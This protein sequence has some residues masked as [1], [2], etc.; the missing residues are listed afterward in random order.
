MIDDGWPADLA[1]SQALVAYRDNL[2]LFDSLMQ[3][4][5]LLAPF[6]RGAVVVSASGNESRADEDPKHRIAVSLPAAADGVISVGALQREKTHF[7][8][9]PFSNTMPRVSAPGVAIKSAG[10]GSKAGLTFKSGTSMACPHVAG[11][12]ALWW[13]SLRRSGERASAVQVESRLLASVKTDV[14][15]KGVAPLDRGD[16]LVTAPKN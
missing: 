7:V 6:D 11:I 3:Q 15:A 5:R 16:G 14:F 13:D 2:R 10:I 8:V 12:A 9:A 1:A 4:V